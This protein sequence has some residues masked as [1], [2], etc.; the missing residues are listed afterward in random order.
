M[1]T[2][3]NNTL[4]QFNKPAILKG[5]GS[6]RLAMF[7]NG[8][9]NELKAFNI[10][11]PDPES[12][13]GSYFDSLA[14]LLSSP[15]VLPERLSAALF[16][17]EKAASPEN[18]ACLESIIQRRI[19]CVSLTGCS[20]ADRA[21]EI[22]FTHPEEL[23]PFAPPVP[24]KSDEGG[25][26]APKSD[27]GGPVA[28]KSDEGESSI[29][30]QN[31]KIENE[32]PD[33]AA[34]TR[35]AQLTPAQYDRVRKQEARLLRIRIETLDAE[36]ARCR[37]NGY[38]AQAAAVVLP[39]IEPWPEPVV[40]SEVLHA[41]VARYVLYLILPRGA[42]DAFALW[43]AHTHCFAAF[44]QTPRLNLQS[45]KPGCGKTTALDV[46][47]SMTPRPLRTENIT[48]PVLF[49]LVD[50]CQPTLLLDEVDSYLP[51]A[52]ELRGLLNAG[53]KRGACAYRCEGD[54]NAVRS[55]KAF[56]PAA[57]AGIGQIPGTLAD[58]S[59]AI[60]LVEAEPGEVA[61][62][63]DE[64]NLE[65]ETV[66]CR[67]LAR[68]AR[69]NFDALKACK[70]ALPATA[71]N[72]LADNWRPLFAIAQLAGGDWPQRA[73]DAFSHLC[74][75]PSTLSASLVTPAR[76]GYVGKAE[77]ASIN[78]INLIN[79]V[80]PALILLSDIRQLFAQSSATRIPTKQLLHSLRALPDRPWHPEL[81]PQ[82]LASHLS[83]FGLR[84]HNIRLGALQT[85]GYDL[86]D[87]TEA[88]ARF[89]DAGSSTPG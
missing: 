26:A 17:L 78:P 10:P 72:R 76:S 36:V 35:L 87:F 6:I 53:H 27:E 77:T 13:N 49:R 80:N 57:L 74:T 61:A 66:L 79:P 2:A 62:R 68:W 34:F 32:D 67:K 12:A 22:W 88:F 45:P 52:E 38:D 56:A 55:F 42:A 19:P 89:L 54:G 81:T 47:A 5:I 30:N 46:I 7:L 69:D 39:A 31:S 73:L 86:A 3:P 8:F 40:L 83:A 44:L 4:T 70:P 51:Q 1:N 41:V 20:A 65:I 48:A 59:I 58:R 28:P 63:F 50:Q 75:A 71:F 33:S 15:A 11:L 82:S 23:L 25:L 85:K 37:Q 21:L 84:S 60:Q 18:H 29:Q 16:T 43:S 14:V 9:T 24:P 64:T